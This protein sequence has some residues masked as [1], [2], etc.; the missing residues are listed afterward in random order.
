MTS[1]RETAEKFNICGSF[2]GIIRFSEQMSLHTTFKVGGPAPLYIKPSDVSSLIFA[3]TILKND[4]IPWF[5]LG[6]GSNIVVSDKGFEGA[7]I[8]MEDINSISAEKGFV[9]CG[10]GSTMSSVVNFC[11]DHVLSGLETFAGLP[12]TAGGALYMNARCFSVSVSDILVSAEYIEPDSLKQKSYSFSG[13]DWEYKKSPFQS[14][15]RIITSVVF[16]TTQLSE[17]VKNEIETKCRMYIDERIKKGHFR[18]PSAGSVF[19][20]NHAFGKPAG[21]IIDEAGLCGYQI[22]GAQIA[23]WHGNFIINKDNAT[24]A[25]IRALVDYT[26]T[27]V[28]S[29]TGFTLEPEIIF[30][31]SSDENQLKTHLLSADSND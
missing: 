1:I 22:G 24:E 25:D 10:A 15:G 21:K 12:G 4:R 16:K 13:T 17:I 31:G 30:C 20:N 11:T 28:K 3:L 18:Y 2:K 14:T 29:K 26:I 5:I 9:R 23:P 27:I 8:S 7:V 19:R 6:C